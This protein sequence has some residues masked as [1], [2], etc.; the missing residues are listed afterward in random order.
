MPWES[1][2]VE[3][4][5]KEF[6]QAAECCNNFSALCREFSITRH[7]GY[8]WV[9]RY[10]AGQPLTDRSRRPHTSPSK[11]PEEVELLILAVRSENPGWGAKTIRDVLLKEG[12]KNIPCAKTVNN[13][14]SICAVRNCIYLIAVFIAIKLSCKTFNAEDDFRNVFLN[15]RN[16]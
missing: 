3:D 4:Q 2:T 14:L 12:H 10:D 11:T 5:R 9:E 6:A 16:C 8:K 13:I 15:A 1:R 7:T